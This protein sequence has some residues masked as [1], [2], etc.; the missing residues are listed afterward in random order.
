MFTFPSRIDL[1]SV[2]ASTI[3]A[4]QVSSTWYSWRACRFLATDSTL[5]SVVGSATRL[6]TGDT[7][8]TRGARRTVKGRWEDQGLQRRVAGDA[9]LRRGLPQQTPVSFVA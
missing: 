1:T 4:S 2:P 3:P 8:K 5:G 7:P 9:E 6:R